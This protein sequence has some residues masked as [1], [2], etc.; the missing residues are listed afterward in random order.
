M[1]SVA[2]NKMKNKEHVAVKK[3]KKSIQHRSG[4]RVLG[5]SLGWPA[6]RRDTSELHCATSPCP[7]HLHLQREH[8]WEN[9]SW[10]SNVFI[11]V[12]LAEVYV[13]NIHNFQEQLYGVLLVSFVGPAW[14]W[15]CFRRA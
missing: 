1:D 3:I 10:L 12:V 6:V 2:T 7:S 4:H 15:C 11:P 14:A 8:R 5:P 13:K 9:C